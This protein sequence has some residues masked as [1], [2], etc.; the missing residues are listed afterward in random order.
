MDQVIRIYIV[1]ITWVALTVIRWDSLNEME[2]GEYRE[3]KR[4]RVCV[5]V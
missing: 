5:C 2:R 3:R 1:T 4:E